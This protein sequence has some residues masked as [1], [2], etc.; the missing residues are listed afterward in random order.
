MGA[1]SR[2]FVD[3]DAGTLGT[4]RIAGVWNIPL[5]NLDRALTRATGVPVVRAEDPMSTVVS[6]SFAA[7]ENMPRRLER[8]PGLRLQVS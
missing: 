5:R 1:R 8:Q 3:L 4:P 6:G 2:F 7:I